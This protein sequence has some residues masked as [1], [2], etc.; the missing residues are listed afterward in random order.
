MTLPAALVRDALAPALEGSGFHR[1]GRSSCWTRKTP[2]LTHLV[3]FETRSGTVR[4]HWGVSCAEVMADLWPQ[5]PSGAEHDPAY[6]VMTGWLDRVP[7]ATASLVIEPSDAEGV[8]S[9][10]R[11]LRRAAMWLARFERRHELVAYLLEVRDDKDRRGF[12]VPANLPLKLTCCAFLLAADG[13]GEAADL[14]AGALARMSPVT[15]R[16]QVSS[17]RRKRLKALTPA[18]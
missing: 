15:S 2:E 1:V 16:D 4:T 18:G 9:L 17:H 3:A 14:A 6:S 12:V 7:G 13:S 5:V 8:A 10:A 11:D